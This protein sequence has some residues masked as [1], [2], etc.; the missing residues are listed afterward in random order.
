MEESERTAGLGRKDLRAQPTSYCLPN[1]V[2]LFLLPLFLFK[3]LRFLLAQDELAQLVR[4]R[5]Q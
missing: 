4:R 1:R 5:W 3:V 2:Q